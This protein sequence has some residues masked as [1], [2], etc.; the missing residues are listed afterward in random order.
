MSLVP[1]NNS[2]N[3]SSNNSS[4]TSSNAVVTATGRGEQTKHIPVQPVVSAV[5]SPSK[6]A[7]AYSKRR[8]I[9][10]RHRV[11]VVHNNHA[12]VHQRCMRQVFTL[13]A[14]T[15]VVILLFQCQFDVG[16]G[17]VMAFVQV[18]IMPSTRTTTTSTHTTT[19]N[20]R[21]RPQHD[22]RYV[23]STMRAAGGGDGDD[24]SNY[25]KKITNNNKSISSQDNNKN[26]NN[27]NNSSSSS[28]SN[29]RR[30]DK[31]H[32][33]RSAP[34]TTSAPIA[35]ISNPKTAITYAAEARVSFRASC[36]EGDFLIAYR[37]LQRLMTGRWRQQQEQSRMQTRQQRLQQQ[38]PVDNANAKDFH[39]LLNQFTMAQ[40]VTPLTLAKARRLMILQHRRHHVNHHHYDDDENEYYQDQQ[41]DAHAAAAAAAAK[42]NSN[43]NSRA[44]SISLSMV[45]RGC[46]FVKHKSMTLD[47]YHSC[48]KANVNV[49]HLNLRTTTNNTTSMTNNEN[50]NAMPHLQPSL[51]PLQS[52]LQHDHDTQILQLQPD[53]IL[54]NS[55]LN[56]LVTCE[57]YVEAFELFHSMFLLQLEEENSDN[58][59]GEKQSQAHTHNSITLEFVSHLLEQEQRR[60]NVNV[61]DERM[62]RTMIP[63][64][65]ASAL[66]IPNQRTYN[67][68]L[69]GL[70]RRLQ[71]HVFHPLSSE[72]Y[73]TDFFSPIPMP[74]SSSSLSSSSSSSDYNYFDQVR[75]LAQHM[76]S[77]QGRTST[78]SN[79]TKSL[80]LWDAVTTNTVVNACVTVGRFDLA[81]QILEQYTHTT[82]PQVEEIE[83]ATITESDSTT[84]NKTKRKKPRHRHLERQRKLESQRESQRQLQHHP[85]QRQHPNVMAYTE[86]LDGYNKANLFAQSAQVWQRMKERGVKPNGITHT[87]VVHSLARQG[88]MEA[89]VQHLREFEHEHS[90]ANEAETEAEP[91]QQQ[92]PHHHNKSSHHHL[93]HL[94]QDRIA[95]YNAILTGLLLDPAPQD[96]NDNGTFGGGDL[97]SRL[98]HAIDLF[99]SMMRQPHH[100]RARSTSTADNNSDNH[101]EQRSSSSS[102]WQ[103]SGLTLP[104]PSIESTSILFQGLARYC[105]YSTSTGSGSSSGANS[106]SNSNSI[107]RHEYVNVASRLYQEL[108]NLE[109]VAYY[110]NARIHTPLMAIYSSVGDLSEVK[111]TFRDIRHDEKDTIALNAYMDATLK[112]GGAVTGSGD[113]ANNVNA[114][115]H[116]EALRAFRAH[117]GTAGKTKT[118]P[119]PTDADA[120][121]ADDAPARIVPNAVT[122]TILISSVLKSWPTTTAS[123]TASTGTSTTASTS[124]SLAVTTA[125][126]RS[127]LLYEDMKTRW[128][129]VPDKTL[130]DRYV[131]T[132][133]AVHTSYCSLLS[134]AIF[135]WRYHIPLFQMLI[136]PPPTTLPPF[137]LSTS[138]YT[139]YFYIH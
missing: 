102:Y 38:V 9:V 125:T 29:K 81:E 39:L 15:L 83:E 61:D 96:G 115:G 67:I 137:F 53:S 135:W 3:T 126:K 68:L 30:G 98:R 134:V 64:S 45:L 73:N 66:A 60:T 25:Y 21:H 34:V 91:G 12:P 111:A 2:S 40:H 76:M 7:S 69:K 113:N 44:T 22:Q 8:M 97:T 62:K 70:S 57:L 122:Y 54:C 87:A 119:S 46:G 84:T 23:Y 26:Q 101:E 5:A 90:N 133:H 118:N 1:C 14:V 138:L 123:T 117:V 78:L 33:R 6:S 139:F 127:M 79:S 100:G 11:R 112:C 20:H 10:R 65:S 108:R 24:R 19:D 131:H 88:D 77:Q 129:I 31:Q 47:I 56:A 42:A 13:A 52:S 75:F 80:N 85:S 104:K 121:S 86:L 94:K 16:C 55:M 4:N 93:F 28:S 58:G 106:N 71:L 105:H 89:L 103:T 107:P 43:S 136:T 110:G 17:A 120:A 49:Q 99:S 41:E 35:I 72:D 32:Q 82:E 95:M 18:N 48:F 37:G 74:F 59:N 27:N 109:Y 114:N 36:Y 51:L 130:V 124:R 92:Q 116:G 63:S 132:V 128:N 50:E